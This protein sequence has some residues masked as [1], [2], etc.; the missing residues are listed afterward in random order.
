MK[1]YIVGIGMDGEK[2]L[3][4]EAREAIRSADALVGAR[5]MIEPFKNL[6]KPT[7]ISWRAEEIG[8]WIAGSR[9]ETVAIP[10][11]GD[12]GFFSAAK[13][14]LDALAGYDPEL[15]CGV[16]SPA[17]FC[18]KLKIPWSEMRFISLHGA[19]ANIIRNIRRNPYCFFLLGGAVSPSD[20]CQKTV[21]YGLGDLTVHI[22]E[23][24]SL[25]NENIVSGRARDLADKSF[26]KLSVMVVENTS[27]E[28]GIESGIADGEFLRGD[29]PMTKA[30]VRGI[31]ISKLNIGSRDVCWDVGSGTG[32][33]SVEMALQ[34]YDGAV[35][36]VDRDQEAVALTKRNAVKFGCDNLRVVLGDAPECLD[37]LPAPDKVFIGG[38]SEGIG[39]ILSAAYQKNPRADVVTAAVSLETL[40]TAARAFD[41]FGVTPEIVQIAVTRTKRIGGHT[42]LAAENPVFLLKGARD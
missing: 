35:Y 15:I 10:V 28:R 27:Y 32:S 40:S 8:E 12:C 19:S 39:A 17:Y 7:F 20:I 5:R 1:I 26:D 24:L 3:T 16:S 11:S 18:S 42:M 33:V 21:K 25:A 14:L 9:Y 41:Q 34:S 38:G 23:N 37:A 6:N 13:P 29:V 4:R 30:E 36:S 2:T 22:G 31:L